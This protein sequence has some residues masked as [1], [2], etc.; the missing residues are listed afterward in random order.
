MWVESLAAEGL[1]VG[2][3]GLFF[4]VATGEDGTRDGKNDEVEDEY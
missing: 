3:F 4:E 2:V 1:L